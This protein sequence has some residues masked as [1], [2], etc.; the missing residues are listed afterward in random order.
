[1][2][3][4]EVR[5]GYQI[6]GADRRVAETQVRAGETSRLLRVVREVSLAVLV[7]VVTDNLYGVLVS[8]YG[9]ISTQT[10]ELSLEHAGTTKCNLLNGRQR[11]EGHVV[12]DTNGEV[13]LG[14]G[15]L[16]KER[17]FDDELHSRS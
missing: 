15:Q 6:G 7:G 9:T 17:Q 13:V 3:S 12:Y 10:I 1:M 4:H 2:A 16:T 11:G 5:R 14:L 8:T